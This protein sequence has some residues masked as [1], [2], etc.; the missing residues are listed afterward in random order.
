LDF[1]ENITKIKASEVAAAAAPSMDSE[2]QY[3]KISLVK[4]RQRIVMMMSMML[5]V[6]TSAVAVHVASRRW[7]SF[8]R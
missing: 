1:C 5:G 2:V 7:L 6:I 3:A 8:F 4:Y